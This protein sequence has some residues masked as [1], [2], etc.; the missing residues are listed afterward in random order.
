MRICKFFCSF[1]PCTSADQAIKMLLIARSLRYSGPTNFLCLFLKFSYFSCFCVSLD[2]FDFHFLYF[3][4]TYLLL[5][6]DLSLA[7]VIIHLDTMFTNTIMITVVFRQNFHNTENFCSFPFFDVQ[8]VNQPSF[9]IIW[10]ACF[11]VWGKFCS[12]K[13]LVIMQFYCLKTQTINF[14]PITVIFSSSI[15]SLI[16]LM[17]S[18]ESLFL[19]VYTPITSISYAATFV[20]LLPSVITFWTSLNLFFK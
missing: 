20:T 9:Y 16:C 17:T 4:F 3:C 1:R 5:K 2:T 7:K 12:F 13:F 11:T 6:S 14:P 10:V 18:F 19:D 15:I 8:M